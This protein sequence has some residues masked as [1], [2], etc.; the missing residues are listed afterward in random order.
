MKSQPNAVAGCSLV[1][2]YVDEGELPEALAH[3]RNGPPSKVEIE[4]PRAVWGG[5]AL[6]AWEMLTRQPGLS[7]PDAWRAAVC[8]HYTDP[9]QQKNALTHTCPKGAFLGL[10]QWGL[11]RGVEP[12]R[13]TDSTASS[14]YALAAIGLLQ[15]EPE[16]ADDK[17]ALEKRVFGARTPNDEVDVVLALRT[18]GLLNQAPAGKQPA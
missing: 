2:E 9:G 16:L 3:L 17:S 7:L 18:Q 1:G 6:R 12:G 14:G 10:C 5:I 15:A 4:R 13:Y 11:V 8:E